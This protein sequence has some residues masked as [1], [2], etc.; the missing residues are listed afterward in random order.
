[1]TYKSSIKENI[2]SF[3]LNIFL[4]TSILLLLGRKDV[5]ALAAMNYIEC[6][7]PVCSCKQGIIAAFAYIEARF[8]AGA[9]LS[10]Q[11]VTGKYILTCKAFHAQALGIAV[12]SV[13]A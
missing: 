8:D 13:A 2:T 10:D 7:N 9:T 11:D 1:M 6:H 5:N 3:L 4:H 12:S